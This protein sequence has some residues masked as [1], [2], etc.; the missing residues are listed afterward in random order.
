M[1][2]SGLI[3][4]A[5][6]ILFDTKT[7]V[8]STV[9][10]EGQPRMRWMSPVFL[11]GYAERIFAVTSTGFKKASDIN[12]NGKV[13]W[14]F[15]SRSLD[16]VITIEGE[17]RI[18]ENLSLKNEVLEA[19]GKQLQTYWKI[20]KD[21]STSTVIETEIKSAVVFYPVEGVKHKVT[22]EKG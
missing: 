19:V 15:Q 17:S 4:L 9:G 20:N 22:F 18:I 14:M 16:T 21:P 5:A 13:Q 12:E 2:K 7:A 3:K 1:D 8:L 6:K 10:E 11:D